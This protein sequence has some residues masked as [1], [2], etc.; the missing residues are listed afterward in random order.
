[1]IDN[2]MALMHALK[3]PDGDNGLHVDNAQYDTS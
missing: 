3:L 1:M 2:T